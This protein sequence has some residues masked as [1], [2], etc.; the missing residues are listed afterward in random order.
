M[1]NKFEIGQ[2]IISWKSVLKT[3]D[4]LLGNCIILY[5][6]QLTKKL[7]TFNHSFDPPYTTFF[8]RLYHWF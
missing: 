5:F 1:V 7:L 4:T 3:P 6:G 8:K 2:D